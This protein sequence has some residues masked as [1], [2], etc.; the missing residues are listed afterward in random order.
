MKNSKKIKDMSKVLEIFDD[1]T[2]AFQ[3]AKPLIDKDVG[4]TPRFYLRCLV[5][6]E[7]FI[8]EEPDPA[9][10]SS[11]EGSASESESEPEGYGYL[12]TT[13]PSAP[14]VEKERKKP[15]KVEGE[16]SE[17]ESSD[18]W[19]M[20]SS[21]ESELEDLTGKKMEE[22]RKFFLKSTTK[23]EYEKAK[24]KVDRKKRREEKEKV[25]EDREEDEGDWK[26]V[27]AGVPMIV[28][29]PK[30]FE[31]DA[32]I[33]REDVLKKLN[34]IMMVRGKKG[35]DT[36]ALLEM[37]AELRTIIDA[38]KFGKPLDAKVLF[39]IVANYFDCNQKNADCMVHDA[40]RNA[41]IHIG[42][43]T[44]LLLEHPEIHCGEDVS[45]ENENV[46]DDSR[47]YRIRSCILTMLERLDDEFTKILQ[48]ADCHSTEY[49]EKLKGEQDLCK[50]MEEMQKHLEKSNASVEEMCRFFIRRISHIYYKVGFKGILFYFLTMIIL[51]H[52]ASGLRR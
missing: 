38:N 28:E 24:K 49:V 41:L 1:L 7:D 21:S 47:P 15:R 33:T 11:V 9:G 23:D 31:K 22:M 36:R 32:E 14:E 39:A 29:K 17:E 12:K 27:S 16:S 26:Q 30:M 51:L 13:A 18:E 3:K 10:Y 44:Q 50:L 43:L 25:L 42:I 19:V 8:N 48:D 20:S 35:T 5:E 34:E 4:F 45:E 6:L 46:I 40:W 52:D 2:R 37:L